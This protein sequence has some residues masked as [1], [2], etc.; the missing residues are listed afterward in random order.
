[1][2]RLILQGIAAGLAVAM[3]V[4]AALAG[5][6]EATIVE[7]DPTNAEMQ[8]SDGNRYEIP[9]DFFVDDLK[10]GLKVLAFFDENGEQKTL[11]D[12]QVLD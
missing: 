3:T 9:V 1:M 2:T 12:L 11:T 10:P 6:V 7:I 5:E 4:G 8:L